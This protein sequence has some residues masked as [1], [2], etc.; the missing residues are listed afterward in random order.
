MITKDGMEGQIRTN[1]WER[2]GILRYDIKDIC[3][4]IENYWYRGW[5]SVKFSVVGTKI[6]ITYLDYPSGIRS[7]F[8]S[9]K[10]HT[11][12]FYLNEKDPVIVVGL[13]PG[14]WD[15]WY[16]EELYWYLERSFSIMIVCNLKIRLALPMD[17]K[18]C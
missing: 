9:Q 15:D 2:N 3:I 4:Q 18:S 16:S 10:H 1:L 8:L 6:L 5:D 7:L 11:W 12:T 17:I 14:F 13:I